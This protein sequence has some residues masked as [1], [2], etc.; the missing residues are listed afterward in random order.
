[1]HLL[2]VGDKDIK[3]SARF[4]DILLGAWS[5]QLLLYAGNSI[6]EV[7]YAGFHQGDDSSPYLNRQVDFEYKDGSAGHPFTPHPEVE[8]N[9]YWTDNHLRGPENGDSA[10]LTLGRTGG[11]WWVEWDNLTRT[12]DADNVWDGASW[13][14]SLPGLDLDP[15]VYVG[16]WYANPRTSTS[17]TSKIE[18][19][20]VEAEGVQV[21]PE[22]ATI[23]LW[24]GL[25]AM[26]LVAAWRRRRAS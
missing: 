16:V 3:I 15:D 1:L 10:I 4:N 14:V 12:N 9:N 5:D 22:P 20:R 6:N 7:V 17:Q 21:V 8:W 19:F 23:V 26:G 11:E 25:G 2:N 24:S 18:W 13:K